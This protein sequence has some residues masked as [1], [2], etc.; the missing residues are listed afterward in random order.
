MDFVICIGLGS[1][2]GILIN[3]VILLKEIRDK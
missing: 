2:T 1:I 3:I